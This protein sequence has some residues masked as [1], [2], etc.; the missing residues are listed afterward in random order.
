[1]L[2]RYPHLRQIRSGWP[3]SYRDKI[4]WLKAEGTKKQPTETGKE[5]VKQE[6]KEEEE[7]ESVGG[8]PGCHLLMTVNMNVC[9]DYRG[10]GC[11]FLDDPQYTRLK[12]LLRCWLLKMN[13]DTIPRLVWEDRTQGGREGGVIQME[14]Q[15]CYNVAIHLRVGDT[16]LHATAT[17]FFENLKKTVGIALV[18]FECVHYHFFYDEEA[19]IEREK[20]EK[21]NSLEEILRM[22]KEPKEKEGPAAVENRKKEKKVEGRRWVE[23]EAP[24]SILPNISRRRWW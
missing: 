20:M 8:D 1:M 17:L 12:N 23:G 2:K 22:E 4:A 6:K 7:E 15:K 11:Y 21:K 14:Q 16:L 10:E 24:F 19:M 18:G 3:D 9:G 13:P 5:E